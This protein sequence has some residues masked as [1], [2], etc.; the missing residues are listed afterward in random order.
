MEVDENNEPHHYVRTAEDVKA[1]VRHAKMD[2][3]QLTQL[4]QAL[5]YPSADVVSDNLRL[6]ELDEHML[7]QIRTGQTLHFKGGLHEKV[8]LCTDECTY[9]VKGAEISNSLLLVPDLKFG[10]ATSTSPL[11]S[12]RTGNANTSLERSLN[13]SADDDLEVPRTLEQ[14][15]VLTIFHDYYECREIRPRY[16]KLGELLQLTRYSGPENE[17][18]V[19]RKLMFS[20]QQL[21]DTIQCSRA[22]FIEGLHQCRALEFDSHIRILDYEYEYRIINLMLGLIAENSWALD[23]V[24][25]GETIYAMQGIAP[26]PIVS[27][28]FD[29]YAKQSDR[30][31]SK[32]RY[33]ESLVARIV[34]QNILQPGLRFRSEE[35]MSTWQEALPEGMSCKLEY[36]HGLGILDKEGAQPC[37]RSLAEEQ[38]PPNINDR[39]RALF[40]TKRKWTLD[41]MEPY[42][43]CFTTPTLSVSQLLAKH[44]RSLTESGTRYFVSKH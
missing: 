4:T 8:V 42:I 21:L 18:C 30:C 31:P 2:E 35:F 9:D 6:L 15:Q 20:F 40:K 1:I 28:L 19:E 32:F 27:G 25:R 38:L 24:D 26:E 22:Q 29:I 11:R 13:D 3:R 12:P 43:D 7:Q 5:Y 14:R 44:A 23:E 37:I 41:E 36:L 39:M 16:R 34:A 10:A 33:E 17:Y